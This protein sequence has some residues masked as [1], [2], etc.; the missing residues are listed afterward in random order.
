MNGDIQ[1]QI[2]AA[3]HEIKTEVEKEQAEQ[4]KMEEQKRKD[5]QEQKKTTQKRN[6]TESRKISLGLICFFVIVAFMV[7]LKLIW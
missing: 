7:F 3:V 4:K 5:E 2:D 1:S 6:S